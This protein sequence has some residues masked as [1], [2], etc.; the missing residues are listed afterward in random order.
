MIKDVE[1]IVS[2]ET[3]ALTQAGFGLPFILA[4][5]GAVPYAE[6]TDL[7]S[8]A[9]D[10]A[11]STEGYKMAA[12]LFG[13]SPRPAKIAMAG[14]EYDDQPNT[15]VQA[16]N[17]LVETHNDWYFLLTDRQDD[18][19]ITALANWIDSQRKLYFVSTDNAQLAAQLESE[20]TV[21]LFH[22]QPRSYPAEGW[23]GVCAPE[24]PGAITWKFKT[25]NGVQAAEI[26]VSEMNQLHDQ[27]GNSYVR[28][29]GVL[30]TSEGK[31]TSGEYIDV[32]RS[33]DFIEARLTEQVS[34]L[35]FT[36]KKV[37]YDNSGIA[38]IVAEC[39]QV[40]KT[41]TNQGIIARDEDGNGMWS[42]TAPRREE[43]PTNDIANR[44]LDGVMA[45]ATLAGAIHQATIR[46]TLKY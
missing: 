23:V 27:G 3:A 26:K 31:V 17:E 25:I 41:A 20:R 1:V 24:L 8:V 30:Q 40:L 29:L 39:E 6:Y 9:E 35:L 46:V 10:Y 44:K 38:L 15:L 33:Q 2:R 43:I 32:I 28:K 5:H 19:A 13:Q 18:E 7:S 22:H 11:E 36:Q 12:R 16:L 34:R 4:T 42:V 14:V 37:P 45:E 21:I